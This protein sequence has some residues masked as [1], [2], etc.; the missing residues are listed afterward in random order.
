MCKHKF[1][2]QALISELEE[3]Y[4]GTDLGG[5]C[6]EMTCH[7]L[8]QLIYSAKNSTLL[9]DMYSQQ[10]TLYY[11]LV[12]SFLFVFTFIIFSNNYLFLS[13]VNYTIPYQCT[14]F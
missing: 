7:F 6:R 13:P 2:L 12:K 14:P 9:F 10:F 8:I 3:D 1:D 4:P 11:C 5:G